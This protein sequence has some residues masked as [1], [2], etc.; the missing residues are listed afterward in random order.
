[1]YMPRA[2]PEGQGQQAA[3]YLCLEFRR[4]T[5]H[6]GTFKVAIANI[7]RAK[8]NQV[9][10]PL[11]ISMHARLS[12]YE[13]LRRNVQRLIKP[14]CMQ[15]SSSTSGL[16][17]HEALCSPPPPRIPAEDPGAMLRLGCC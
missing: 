16:V 11:L 15:V 14:P 17:L 2:L 7:M 6:V 8:S 10:K 13:I 5:A 9:N 12:C 1:M 4:G 3:E